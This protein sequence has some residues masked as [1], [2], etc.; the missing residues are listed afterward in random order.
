[1]VV[2][3]RFAKAT[4][5]LAGITDKKSKLQERVSKLKQKAVENSTKS[6]KNVSEIYGNMI[7]MLK[8]RQLRLE[9]SIITNFR[10][11]DEKFTRLLDELAKYDIEDDT[12]M[13]GTLA[14]YIENNPTSFS[15]TMME[16][17][18]RESEKLEE[19]NTKSEAQ[20][21]DNDI[22]VPMRLFAE[23][24]KARILQLLSQFCSRHINENTTH[25]SLLPI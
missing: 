21:K 17:L 8:E 3:H 7:D 19:S 12:E 13:L 10:T 14:N 16:T 24:N 9:E 25:E 18:T 2:K 23:H 5:K 15:L 6:L 11:I 4:M 22:A 20:L 1:M